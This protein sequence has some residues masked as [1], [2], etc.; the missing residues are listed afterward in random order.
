[1][2]QGQLDVL[3]LRCDYDDLTVIKQL[4]FS[5]AAGDI[6][7]LLGPSGCGKSTILR[8]IAGFESIKDGRIE[9]DQIE[10]SSP[11]K[12]L[13]PEKRSIGMVFQDYALFP[14]L[15]IRQNIEFGLS[16]KSK[17]ER[18]ARVTELMDLVDLEGYEDR[19]PHELSGG[20]QQRVALARALAPKPSLL[21]LDEPFSNLDAELRTRLGVDIRNI[22]KELKISAI[23]VTHDQKEAFAMADHIGVI[24][25]GRIQQWGRPFELY[26][27]PVNRFVACFIGHG[28][29]ISGITASHESFDSELGK[30]KGNRAY[31]YPVGGRVDIL[32]RP[33]DVIH[34]PDSPLTGLV[35][36]KTFAGTNTQY[37]IKLASENT[38]EASFPSHQ[39]LNIGDTVHFELDTEHL[40]AYPAE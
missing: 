15:N 11:T 16:R 10:I 30:I 7:C 35:T 40:I 26:H 24:E 14:H 13:A 25:Q 18:N 27:E 6:C 37:Q 32:I 5:L 1:M 19:Y 2:T 29:F 21:L 9:L 12:V 28:S 20:Q 22:L 38:L 33:D 8:A 31:N 36:A 3:D 17:V 39:D 4:S 34:A 23:L